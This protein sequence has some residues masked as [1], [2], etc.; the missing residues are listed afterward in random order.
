MRL[1]PEDPRYVDFERNILGKLRRTMPNVSLRL[2]SDSRSGL[3]EAS[4]DNYGNVLYLYS[5]KQA[6]SRSTGAGEVLPLIYGLAGVERAV[7]TESAPYPGYPLQA[8]T[9]VAK[10]WFYGV[11]P[12]LIISG[13]LQSLHGFV[14]ARPMSGP[15]PSDPIVGCQGSSQGDA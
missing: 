9:G 11:L 5:G 3:F 8:G 4:A 13:W 2:E 15:H 6:E 1:A 14:F 10:V 12:L 7:V